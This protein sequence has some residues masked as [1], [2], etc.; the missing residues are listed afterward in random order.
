MILLFDLGGVFVPDST[1]VLNREIACYIEISE[2]ELVRP[3]AKVLPL[4]F[5]GK[6]TILDFYSALT[7]GKQDPR[8][9]LAK[10][11]G[12][13]AQRFQI[14][15]FMHA[16]LQQFNQQHVTACLT[17]TEVEIAQINRT[18]GLYD[19]FHH[20]LLSTEMGLMKPEPEIFR[21]HATAA[22]FTQRNHFRG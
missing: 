6:M 18:N 17:N 12:I 8:L 4:L 10:H 2:A 19:L 15:P 22:R 7:N 5:T 3:W 16:L 13:Y 21:L 20:A 9:V 14:D 1:E 11:L